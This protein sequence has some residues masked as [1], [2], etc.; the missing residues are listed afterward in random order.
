LQDDIGEK[1]G[2]SDARPDDRLVEGASG[3]VFQASDAEDHAHFEKNDGHRKAASH[4]VAVLLNFALENERE[5]DGGGGHPQNGVSGSGNAERTSAAQALLEVLDVKAEGRGDENAGNIEAS[6]DAMK[7]GEAAAETVGELHRTKQE[8]ART[9]Q[10][11]RQ[12]PPLKGLDVRPFGILGVNEEML[13]VAKN[14][15]E[16]E[17]DKSKQN[18]FWARPREA[19]G[20]QGAGRQFCLLN[21][22]GEYADRI[23]GKAVTQRKKAGVTFRDT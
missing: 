17:A 22:G 20:H 13:V 23:H 18:I 3:N 21:R 11:V 15:G 4:P 5:G 1:Q 19:R 7:L 9:H 2:E 10:A 6:D 12:E 8:G 14:V 16:H